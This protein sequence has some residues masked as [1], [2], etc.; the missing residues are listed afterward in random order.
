MRR[1]LIYIIV[2]CAGV[3]AAGA[4][5]YIGVRG[6]MGNGTSR[7]FP[8]R[9]MGAVW[10]LKSGGVSWKFYTDEVFVGGIEM[11]AVW[12]QQGYREYFMETIEGTDKRRRTGYYQ[13]T[14]DEVMVPLMWQPHA[15]MFKQRLR[16]F[17]NAGVTLSYI[18][19]SEQR[20]VDYDTGSDVGEEYILKEI[21]DNRFG[22]GLCGGGGLTW[23]QGR[24]ELFVEARYHIGYSDILKNRN[25]YE[26][27]PLRSPLDGIQFQAGV[28]FRLG[29]GGVRSEQGRRKR[30]VEPVV[31]PEMIMD[32]GLALPPEPHIDPDSNILPPK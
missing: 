21:R 17:L 5:H 13:R 26:E 23:I 10:G 16:V 15:Y 19:S 27:N 9:E 20:R 2:C 28:F 18:L 1:F 32:P 24:M 3:G 11:D 4:Q 14:V 12:M 29:K 6:G 30:V 7:L 31:E 25:K 22:Y 8:M